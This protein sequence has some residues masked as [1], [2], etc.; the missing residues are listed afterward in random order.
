MIRERNGEGVSSLIAPEASTHGLE[1][2]LSPMLKDPKTQRLA[3]LRC[4]N[5]RSLKKWSLLTWLSPMCIALSPLSKLR[6]TD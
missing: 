6:R 5:N 2:C 1:E 4:R 3:E